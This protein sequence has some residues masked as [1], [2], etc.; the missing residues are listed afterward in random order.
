MNK[1]IV[2]IFTVIAFSSIASAKDQLVLKIGN[3]D[4]K[5]NH[6]NHVKYH[7][8]NCAAC[9][10]AVPQAEEAGKVDWMFCR[11]CHDQSLIKGG[12]KSQPI[13]K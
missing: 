9:H 12:L 3:K 10:P 6:K 5:F 2:A 1:I 7:K 8:N 4:V 13:R 11:G